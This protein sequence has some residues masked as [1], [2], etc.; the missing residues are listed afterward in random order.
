MFTGS[1]HAHPRHA[2]R[3]GPRAWPST[4]PRTVSGRATTT[5]SS[6]TLRSPR[7]GDSTGS[8]LPPGRVGAQVTLHH[9]GRHRHD[10]LAGAVK[11]PDREET[12]PIGP[13][14]E[15]LRQRT[16]SAPSGDARLRAVGP[17]VRNGGWSSG[18]RGLTRAVRRVA[19]EGADENAGR[20]GRRRWPLLTAVAVDSLGTGLYLP[21]SLLYF[22]KVTDL[23]LSTIGLLISMTTALTLPVPMV[24]GWLVDRLGPR[25]VVAGGQT[26]QGVGF[27]LYLTVSGAGSLVVAVLVATVGL[28]VYWSSVFTLIAD[29]A[30]TE[31]SDAKDHWFARAGMMRETGVGGGALLTG[32]ALTFDSA[33]VYDGLILGSALAFLAAALVVVLMVPSTPHTLP[34]A[35]GPSGHRAL[36]RDR[37]YLA[38]IG[39][40]TIFALCSTFLALSLPVYVVQGLSGPGWVSG[41]LLALNTLLLAT[42]TA[43]LTRFVRRRCTRPRA[44]AWAGGLWTLWCAASAAAVL[45]PSDALVPFLVAVVLCYTAAEMIYGPASN[46]LAA[47]AAPAGS[48]GTYL[49]AFQYSFAVAN[50]LAPGLFGLLFSQDRLLPWLA[51]GLLAALGAGLMLRLERRLPREHRTP[52]HRGSNPWDGVPESTA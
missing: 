17:R 51:V 40:C 10:P 8:P 1:W 21:L 39:T 49:A 52:E 42:C 22:L 27:L 32:V 30:D 29:Q 12:S 41:P 6:S 34:P 13:G 11:P 47:D 5:A 20:S 38:L 28:R 37:P 3:S 43:A 31:R 46:A 18:G 24:V 45:L 16:V 19:R 7:T 48:R 23:D 33:R 25:L 2:A 14:E 35:D 50:I 36:L 44:L 9:T 4:N 15:P 26:L